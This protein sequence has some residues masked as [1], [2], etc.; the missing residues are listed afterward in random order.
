MYD[1][2]KLWFH[3]NTLRNTGSSVANHVIAFDTTAGISTYSVHAF[4]LFI[5]IANAIRVLVCVAFVDVFTLFAII[6]IT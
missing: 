4:S 6:D 2:T 1:L 5:L 3:N